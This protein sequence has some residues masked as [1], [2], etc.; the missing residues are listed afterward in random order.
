[1]PRWE[2]KL[3]V[4][5]VDS[6]YGYPLDLGSDVGIRRLQETLDALGQFGW[7]LVSVAPVTTRRMR[8]AG[9]S[10]TLWVFKR[11]MQ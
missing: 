10:A 5:G 4:V 8:D 6:G 11:L 1:M 9:T 7:E 2:Y 3:E